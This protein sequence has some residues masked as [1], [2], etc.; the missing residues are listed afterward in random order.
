MSIPDRNIGI[1]GLDPRE[2]T[3]TKLEKFLRQ[4][5][6]VRQFLA[7]VCAR[8]RG[9]EHFRNLVLRFNSVSNYHSLFRGQ[10]S[11]CVRETFET[12]GYTGVAFD[13][14]AK[15][16]VKNQRETLRSLQPASNCSKRDKSRDARQSLSQFSAVASTGYV[17]NIL[18]I[19]RS[20]RYGTIAK[21]PPSERLVT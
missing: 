15:F 10:P 18:I 3:E 2:R 7:A 5:L 8:K 14:F 4:F 16:L 21:T 11:K 13:Y 12:L 17:A 20:W 6:D 19:W 9:V 1:G